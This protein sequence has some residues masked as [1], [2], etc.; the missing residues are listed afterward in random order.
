MDSVKVT[1]GVRVSK[2]RKSLLKLLNPFRKRRIKK[3][4]EALRTLVGLWEN[5]DTSFFDKR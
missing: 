2:S 5:K 4:K 1:Y 3:Q